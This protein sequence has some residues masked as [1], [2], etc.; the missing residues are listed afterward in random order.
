MDKIIKVFKTK[1]D[2]SVNLEAGNILEKDNQLFV[3]CAKGVIE[4]L[5]IQ[6]EGRKKMMVAEFLRGYSFSNK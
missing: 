6:S 1:L 5:E 4:I 2:N 3:G